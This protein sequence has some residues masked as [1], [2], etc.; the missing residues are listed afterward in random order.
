MST[1][2]VVGGPDWLTGEIK[3]KIWLS[4]PVGRCSIAEA[5]G[6]QPWD[7]SVDEREEDDD[8][9]EALGWK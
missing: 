8:D 2:V 6:F 7:S 5:T 9:S 4:V 1:R 3:D